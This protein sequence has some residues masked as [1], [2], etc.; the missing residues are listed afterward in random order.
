MICKHVVRNS[1]WK[2]NKHFWANFTSP[3]IHP[4]H[5]PSPRGP[6]V[7]EYWMRRFVDMNNA[8]ASTVHILQVC[9]RDWSG[10]EGSYCNNT[11]VICCSV[12]GRP[13]KNSALKCIYHKIRSNFPPNRAKPPSCLHCDVTH[14]SLSTWNVALRIPSYFETMFK[15]IFITLT[16]IFDVKYFSVSMANCPWNIDKSTLFWWLTSLFWWPIMT[17]QCRCKRAFSKSYIAM[18]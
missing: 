5:H 7:S 14:L 16:L 1:T 15:L 3:L 6:I 13:N 17:S 8:M 2:S 9:L 10:L 18:P 11:G 12:E 4:I